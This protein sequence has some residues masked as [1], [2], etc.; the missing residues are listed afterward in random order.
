MK[1]DGEPLSLSV[2]I[3]TEC[4]QLGAL[5]AQ[6]Q[7]LPRKLQG[8]TAAPTSATLLEEGG[9]DFDGKEKKS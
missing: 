3:L 6:L 8:A 7:G 5:G 4:L 9:H 1:V 2:S